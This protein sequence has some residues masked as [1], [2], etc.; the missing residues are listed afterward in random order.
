[1]YEHYS[2]SLFANAATHS[3][4][5][6]FPYYQQTGMDDSEEN[7]K[8]LDIDEKSTFHSLDQFDIDF[9]DPHKYL[10]GFYVKKPVK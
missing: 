3:K 7:L 9:P 1:L 2:E 4:Y 10:I 6:T 5:W 8:E